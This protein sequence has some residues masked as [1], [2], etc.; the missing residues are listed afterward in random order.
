MILDLG[1]GQLCWTRAGHPPPLLVEPDQTRYLTDGAGG[2]LGV[3]RRPPYPEAATRIEPGT[4]LLLYTDGLIERRGQVLDEGLEHLAATAAELYSAPPTTLLDGLLAAALPD[5]GPADDIALIAAHYLPAPL[6]QRLPAD[7]AR[8]PGLRRA[9]RAR[10]RA[11]VLP[12][13]LGEDLQI[14]LGGS[15]RQRRR[16]RLRHHQ[17][18]RRVHLPAHPPW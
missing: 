1:S 13:A 9:V 17:R 16:T 8:L 5:T 11:G 3:I 7:P 12:A 2:P 6:H 15:R 14:T 18:T 4:C 10:T